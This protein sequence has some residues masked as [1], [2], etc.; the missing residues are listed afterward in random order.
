[1]NET[2]VYVLASDRGWMW[3][4]ETDVYVWKVLRT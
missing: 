4:N 1:M 2:D 3:M